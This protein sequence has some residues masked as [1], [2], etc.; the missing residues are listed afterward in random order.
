MIKSGILNK[1]FPIKKDRNR[2]VDNL[3]LINKMPSIV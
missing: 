2:P 3:R 1:E